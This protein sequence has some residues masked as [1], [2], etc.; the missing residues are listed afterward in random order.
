MSVALELVSRLSE[1]REAFLRQALQVPNGLVTNR[2]RSH[3][4]SVL[5]IVAHMSDVDSHYLKQAVAMRDGRDHLFIYFD[6]T[7]WKSEHPAILD[8][9]WDE[10]LLRIRQ[11]HARVL[12]T[13]S[14]LTDSE[15][16]RPGRHPR[17]IPYTVR[18]VF[19]RYPRHDQNH[20]EQ[21]RTTLKRLGG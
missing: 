19:L 14:Q 4:W 17:G 21:I 9:P 11:S 2:P 7:R 18:D 12:V 15:L 16:A 13:L 1:S 5:E 10:V 8:T 6:D 3:E 20:T